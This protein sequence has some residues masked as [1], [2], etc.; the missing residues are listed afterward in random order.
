[1]AALASGDLQIVSN[2]QLIH[3]GFD[4]PAVG[5]LILARPTQSLVLHVQMIG[6]GLRPA[7]GKKRAVILDHAGN[8][9]RHGLPDEDQD[10]SLTA[11]KRK[12]KGAEAPA[13]ACPE[14]H[15]IVPAAARSC[16]NCGYAFAIEREIETVLGE[17][18][19]I[20]RPSGVPN[21][22]AMSYRRAV[23]WAG[24]DQHKLQ[25]VARARGYK[26]GW[27]YHRLQDAQ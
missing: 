15:A 26:E 5:A 11:T 13:K 2:C 25:L 23:R 18:V 9:L 22:R 3:E 19:A 8:S 6:R 21:L 27:V 17:L 4:A 14:C 7:P 12:A 1:M 24:R 20:S 10:W 16:P